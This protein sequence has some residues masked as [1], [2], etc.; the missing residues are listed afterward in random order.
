MRRFLLY[1]SLYDFAISYKINHRDFQY[2]KFLL[3]V[4]C[5]CIF[6]HQSE[7]SLS[8]YQIKVSFLKGSSIPCSAVLCIPNLAKNYQSPGV[9][10]VLRSDSDSAIQPLGA[11]LPHWKIRIIYLLHRDVVVRSFFRRKYMQSTGHGI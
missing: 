3:S 7:T 6:V 2:Q 11:S 9:Q 4:F 5:G 10:M 8:P 1:L